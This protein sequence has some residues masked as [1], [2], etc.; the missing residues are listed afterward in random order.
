VRGTRRPKRAAR[1][2]AGAAV[3]RTVCSDAG[4][5][6]GHRADV[7]PSDAAIVW[8]YPC[9]L[10]VI[11]TRTAEGPHPT[12]VGGEKLVMVAATLVVR[13]SRSP[14]RGL[15]TNERAGRHLAARSRRVLADLC[16][17]SPVMGR[18]RL[19]RGKRR[20]RPRGQPVGRRRDRDRRA[21]GLRLITVRVCRGAGAH[22]WG[23]PWR[24][25]RCGHRFGRGLARV[26][27]A[28]GRG[29]CGGRRTSG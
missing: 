7:H 20:L 16:Q 3:S 2:P 9:Q 1:P 22:R 29:S 17:L 28:R 14:C 21:A 26:L 12:R 8:G 11:R 27:R 15:Y 5:R 25:S 24:G 23:W 4:R 19:R 18:A 6:L 10:M 13:R